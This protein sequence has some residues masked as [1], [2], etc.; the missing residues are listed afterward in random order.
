MG[1]LKEVMGG[2]IRDN[3]FISHHPGSKYSAEFYRVLFHIVPQYMLMRD[4]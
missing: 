1:P 3:V 4:S 2:G